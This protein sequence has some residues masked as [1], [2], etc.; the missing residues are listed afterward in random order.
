Q[1]PSVQNTGAV[2]GR[3]EMDAQ[4]PAFRSQAKTRAKA[5]GGVGALTPQMAIQA[6]QGHTI[7]KRFPDGSYRNM[8]LNTVFAPGDFIRVTVVTRA[9]G[10][11]E[12][13]EW[14]ASSSSWKR[15]F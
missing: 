12:L 3:A 8:P 13:S 7:A 10:E 6:A 14:D 2:G 9:T 5:V 1:A 11:L 15:V 4:A